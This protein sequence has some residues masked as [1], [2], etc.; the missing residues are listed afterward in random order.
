GGTTGGGTGGAATGGSTGGSNVKPGAKPTMPSLTDPVVAQRRAFALSF[1]SF[2]PSL[3]IPKLPP[4]PNT[5]PSLSAA[6]PLPNGTYLPQLPYKPQTE[7][8][9]R[10]I[11]SSTPLGRVTSLDEAGLAKS[12]AF[13]LILVAA[14]AHL[15]RFLS[16]HVE[17]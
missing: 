5:L 2:S 10:N 4:L 15:R 7:T 6:Q 9:T 16:S 13:A 11:L 12:I 17:D 14:A 3:G 8:K 1:N